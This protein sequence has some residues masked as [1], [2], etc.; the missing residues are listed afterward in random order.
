MRKVL[1]AGLTA[2]VLS[3][4]AITPAFAGEY[5]DADKISDWSA[6]YIQILTDLGVVVGY[7]DGS[8]KPAANITREEMSVML[9]K[10][11]IALEDS[12]TAS[13]N[14]NDEVLYEEL[15]AQQT[16]LLKALADIDELKAKDAV[17]HNNFVAIS[18]KYNIDNQDVDD[19]AYIELNGKFQVISISKTFKVS[20]R[21]F[22]NTTG[23][24]GGAATLD[25]KLGKKVTVFGG[26][27]AAASWSENGAL[28]GQQG[29]VGYGTAGVD[30]NVGKDV[31]ITLDGKVPFT[32]DNS[33]EPQVGLGVGVRF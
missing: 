13:I 21:P 8:F 5:T 33:G 3:I 27:G 20:I 10:G 32:G 6:D 18:M 12:I 15:V 30:F 9:L 16:T 23:E 31:V 4:G 25:A 29:V 7:P 17:E 19:Q 1:F 2:A 11:M 26:A 24:A 28:T 22:V 14:A